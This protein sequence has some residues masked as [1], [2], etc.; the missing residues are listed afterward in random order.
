MRRIL[1]VLLTALIL[2]AVSSR[3]P[4]AQADEPPSQVIS[5]NYPKT[6]RAGAP[7]VVA[8]QVSYSSKFGMMDIGIWDPVIGVVIQSLVSNAT[9]SGAG[10]STFTFNLT[11]PS[12][13]GPWR[14]TA[15][16]R[17]WLQDAWFFDQAGTYEFAVVVA[18]SAVLT[19]NGIPQDSNV[20]LD[21]EPL[22]ANGSVLVVPLAL[23]TVHQLEV[24]SIIAEGPGRRIIF[25]GWVDGLKSDIR[26]IVLN[27][28]LSISP[29]YRT[30]YFL[31]VASDFGLGA[32]QGWY[33]KG[34]IVQFGLPSTF[35]QSPAFLGLL[36]DNYQFRSWSGDSESNL[37]V[38]TVL[39][40]GAKS[41]DAKWVHAGTSLNLEGLAAVF[42]F[43]AA[44]L[45]FRALRTA[46]G[47]HG[48]HETPKVGRFTV[49]VIILLL[50][51]ASSAS[52]PVFG[53]L[54]LP[55]TASVVNIGDASWY[56]WSQ[57]GSDTCILWLGG[58]LEYSQGGY[59]I[60]PYEYESF[61]TIKFLQELAKYY[62]VVA[63]EK[64]PYPSPA[65]ENRTIF[66]ELAQG[67][68]SVATQLHQ[69]INSQGYRHV[70]LV[71]YS[72]GT[73]VAATVATGYPQTWNA[74]DGLI[75]ITA[76]LPPS[77]IN[78]APNLKANLLLLYG[79]A[80][81]FEPTGQKFYQDA[82]SE[83]W[84]GPAYFHKEFHL[85]D[86]M[87][88]EVWSPLKDNTYSPIALGSTVNFIE[89]SKALQFGQFTI[90]ISTVSSVQNWTYHLST[91]HAPTSVFWGEP[92]SV[93]ATLNSTTSTSAAPVAVIAYN[94]FGI[95]SAVQFAGGSSAANVRLV[96]PTVANLS[97]YS[98][99]LLVLEKRSNIWQ[100]VS[101]AYPLTLVATGQIAL[102]VD[103]LIPNSNLIF[104]GTAYLVS[105]TGQVKIETSKGIHSIEVQENVDQDKVHGTFLQWSDSKASASRT[106][107]LEEN[108]SISAVYRTQ[109]YVEVV[110]PYGAPKGTGWYDA[111]S[112]IEP[113][114]QPPTDT[115][116]Y[117]AF[118]YWSSGNRSYGLG[119]PIRVSSPMTIQATWVQAEISN[120]VDNF[121]IALLAAS[122]FIFSVMLIF[123][124]KVARK[125]R[126]G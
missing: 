55:S 115:Q 102:E 122:I 95:L 114:I 83:G 67:Q 111:N 82:P 101:P 81:D 19:L 37:P 57:P 4:A 74:A 32:G 54:P 25:D 8:V 31:S 94:S 92:F 18:E 59:L 27:G 20:L 7:F 106:L 110:S 73:D 17:V 64:G 48:R 44:L 56:Y 104:D 52:L 15:I 34:H 21:G 85:L 96:M 70:F 91:I 60:N 22:K 28:S 62:C 29:I 109:Y 88:H 119:E 100:V 13:I 61:G 40:D 68:F 24:P 78:G 14:L 51:V 77:I 89:K 72:V 43:A 58:G 105:P 65:F 79:H 47:R 30:Q 97:E 10:R 11:A 53:Q 5:V 66:Q 46:A 116:Q 98:F 36:T 3:L 42:L 69:W 118:S 41:V 6:V 87:G 117:L 113:V 45:G 38:S 123:N 63:L 107:N 124:L 93:N 1:V 39:M 35:H 99:S 12:A 50:S 90:P 2:L 86:E 121:S 49:I 76:W 112:T 26:N 71:G 9:L 120:A 126:V 80:P 75:L 33:D 23:G 125:S 16:T 108:A 103:G 84:H